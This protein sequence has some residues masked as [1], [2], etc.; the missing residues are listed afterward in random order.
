M[1]EQMFHIFDSM[2]VMLFWQSTLINHTGLI[3]GRLGGVH[4]PNSRRRCKWM[5][6]QKLKSRIDSQQPLSTF[7]T[8]SP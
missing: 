4:K 5:G 2:C 1:F 6:G 7:S 3:H 8:F